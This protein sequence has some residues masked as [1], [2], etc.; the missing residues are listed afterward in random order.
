MLH[1]FAKFPNDKAFFFFSAPSDM[2]LDHLVQKGHRNRTARLKYV[3]DTRCEG[4]EDLQLLG[5]T[6]VLQSS[7][8]QQWEP[9]SMESLASPF[10][11][12][13]VLPKCLFILSHK[14]GTA[15]HT[16][17]AGKGQC[18]RFTLLKLNVE[19]V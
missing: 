2:A 3:K 15:F 11:L 13:C 19:F 1:I 17:G 16:G 6:R 14:S 9:V 5:L 12:L 10:L 18:S 7:A 8:K 4:I